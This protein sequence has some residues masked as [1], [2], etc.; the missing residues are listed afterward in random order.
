MKKIFCVL[1]IFAL[2]LP[3][4]ACGRD[5]LREPGN[6]YYRRTETAFG[7]ADPVIAPEQK[8][9]SAWSREPQSLLA[10]YFAG[11][12]T[13][14]LVAPY[15]RD[16]RVVRWDITDSTLTLTMND[17]FAAMTGVELTLACACITK[18]FLELLPVEQVRFQ[19]E[20]ALLDG[21]KSLLFSHDLIRL[22]DDSLDQARATFSVYY[23]DRSRRYLLAT[24]LSVNLATENDLIRCLAEALLTPP[25]GSGLYTALPPGTKLLD[26]SV[27]D[28]I[29]TLN[30]SGE[31]ERNGWH[32]CEAQRLSL[33]SL[34]N[35][36]TQLEEIDSVEFSLEGNLLFQYGLLSISAPLVFDEGVIGPV[37][38]GMNEFD[39]TI[40]LANGSS[41]Y[42][43]PVPTRI[44]QT[45][46]L[47][48]AELIVA[49]L[50]EYQAL[51]GFYS[52]IPQGT[53]LNSVSV[54]NGTCYLDFSQEFLAD[55]DTL[56]LSVRSIVASVCTVENIRSVQISVN[57][58]KPS[59][60]YAWLFATLSPVPDW[61][62]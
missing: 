30:F 36:L 45:G 58:A 12:T 8:E 25:E 27:D 48:E 26:Y 14:A 31:F 43:A 37:R 60:E 34:V 17:A 39:A 5:E 13:E 29:C 6:F 51:N 59:G 11:P 55:P 56:V 24:D 10:L 1:L 57:G 20:S 3:L 7:E 41:P 2:L 9:L 4:A 47:S 49:C 22:S 40:Y 62:L 44:R 19:A 16:T 23:T 28:G 21:D 35:T 32:T 46:G 18:T 50:L 53:L 38:T 15:P 61:F 52:T 42:L 54:R 33:L